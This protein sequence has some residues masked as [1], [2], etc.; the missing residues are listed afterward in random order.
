MIGSGSFG[1]VY[2]GADTQSNAKVAAKI[3]DTPT[4]LDRE[5]RVYQHLW[6]YKHDGFESELHIPKLLWEGSERGKRVLVLQRLGPSLDKLYDRMGKRWTTPTLLWIVAQGI[7]LLRGLHR[8]GIVHRD[9]KPDNFAI[10]YRDRRKLFLLDFGLS[11]QYIDAG[12]KHLPPR[13]EEAEKLSLIGTMRYASIH[14]HRGHQ[15]SRR[16]DLESL[17]YTAA[18]FW[19]GGLPWVH[20]ADATADRLEKGARI[21]ENKLRTAPALMATLHPLLADFYQYVRQLDYDELPMYN[22]W[23]AH[24]EE[25]MLAEAGATESSESPPDWALEFQHVARR[26]T[27]KRGRSSGAL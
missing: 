25:A 16:D 3:E 2:K 22:A 8:L 9:I 24:F 23:I 20:L 11:F 4:L 19:K 10:G 6:K 12:G 27:C 5:I 14:N 18:Y 13:G 7:R 26:H 15:Q 17:I 1:R 21:L